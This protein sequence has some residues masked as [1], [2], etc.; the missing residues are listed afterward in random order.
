MVLD[1]HNFESREPCLETTARIYK[2]H[3]HTSS[4]SSSSSSNQHQTATTRTLSHNN[5]K[6]NHKY[7]NVK[8]NVVANRVFSMRI[9]ASLLPYTAQNNLCVC[10]LSSGNMLCTVVP[11]S[12]QYIHHKCARLPL[13][14]FEADE[15]RKKIATNAVQLVNNY[16]ET[17]L[18]TLFAY[19]IKNTCNTDHERCLSSFNSLHLVRNY[20]PNDGILSI[21]KCRETTMFFI[22]LFI[23][24]LNH[25]TIIYCDLLS[26]QTDFLIYWRVCACASCVYCVY[27]RVECIE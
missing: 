27:L 3:V 26:A 1:L 13:F 22:V 9:F 17:F 2:H 11:M 10:V 8:G 7:G 15:R 19:H 12:L 20:W 4:N 23:I 24:L 16:N 14:V 5:N 6:N 25:F 18:R 21:I